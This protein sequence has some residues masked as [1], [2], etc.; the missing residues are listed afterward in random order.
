MEKSFISPDE[1]ILRAGVVQFKDPILTFTTRRRTVLQQS[2]HTHV[3]SNSTMHG[4]FFLPRFRL[5]LR[6]TLGFALE[7]HS[8][9][10][11]RFNQ[12]C[13]QHSLTQ[14]SDSCRAKSTKTRLLAQV[15]WGLGGDWVEGCK[16]K[17]F[18]FSRWHR[19]GLMHWHSFLMCLSIE[20]AHEALRL[21]FFLESRVPS[22]SSSFALLFPPG[23]HLPHNSFCLNRKSTTSPWLGSKI[24]STIFHQ[25]SLFLT[26]C[27]VSGEQTTLCCQ[28]LLSPPLQLCLNSNSSVCSSSQPAKKRS[29]AGMVASGLALL[30]LAFIEAE[31]VITVM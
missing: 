27:V 15:V 29:M 10:T 8:S 13:H 26:L 16:P 25:S 6:E 7:L 5:L 3:G 31:G 9:K 22:S 23:F 18:P 4:R 28:R 14:F 21:L 2:E 30:S 17:S 20:S 1:F 11:N 12:L 24:D 19:T